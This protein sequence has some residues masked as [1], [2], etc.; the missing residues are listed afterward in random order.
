MLDSLAPD[1]LSLDT[2]SLRGY[3]VPWHPYFNN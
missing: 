3:D 2:L 1:Y